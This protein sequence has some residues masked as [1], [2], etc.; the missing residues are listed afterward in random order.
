MLNGVTCQAKT[1]V[2]D[3]L[4]TSGT[5]K[6]QRKFWECSF[7]CEPESCIHPD[8]HHQQ[9]VHFFSCTRRCIWHKK[10]KKNTERHR[11]SPAYDLGV[12]QT[13][14]LHFS[15]RHCYKWGWG[16]MFSDEPKA[17]NKNLF[18]IHLGLA[19][20]FGKWLDSK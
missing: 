9:V 17:K 18:N 20:I 15:K 12:F 13:H 14:L 19:N 16:R 8:H 6:S 7:S 3:T 11:Q 1:E 10:K 2:T 4:R 5:Q